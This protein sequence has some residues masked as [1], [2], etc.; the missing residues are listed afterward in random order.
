MYAPGPGLA[1][2]AD[3]G[4][5]AEEGLPMENAE[6]ENLVLMPGEYASG[7]GVPAGAGWR[8]DGRADDGRPMENAAE[9]FLVSMDGV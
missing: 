4:R 1:G 6:A 2:Y 3:V 5:L 9:L 7:P 8:R